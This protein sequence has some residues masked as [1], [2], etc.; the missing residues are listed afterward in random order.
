MYCYNLLFWFWVLE[1][2]FIDIYTFILYILAKFF[3]FSC[4]MPLIS[5]LTD[6][7]VCVCL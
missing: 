4:L 5:K 2:F 7:V 6:C 3:C 1:V